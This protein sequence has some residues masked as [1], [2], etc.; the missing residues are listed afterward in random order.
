M[1]RAD[2]ASQRTAGGATARLGAWQSLES[3][4]NLKETFFFMTVNICIF[5]KEIIDSI[6]YISY[7]D[8]LLLFVDISG[9]WNL[10]ENPNH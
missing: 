6:K 5:L 8:M 3:G 7:I 1:G 10:W 9:S 4:K 2:T